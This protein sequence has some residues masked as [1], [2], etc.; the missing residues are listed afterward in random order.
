[1]KS[2]KINEKFTDFEFSINKLK[3]ILQDR[4]NVH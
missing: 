4:L 1:M 2:K 3:D